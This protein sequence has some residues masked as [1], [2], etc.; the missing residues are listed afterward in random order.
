[1]EEK[2]DDDR[3]RNRRR[4]LFPDETR[5]GDTILTGRGQLEVATYFAILD[6][7]TM[8]LNKRYEA[9]DGV[10]KKIRFV[11]TLKESA[12]EV[13]RKCQISCRDDLEEVFSTD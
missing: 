10:F 5:E 12:Q 3:Q 4:K 7:V 6:R 8:E 13:T 9:Y 11:F 1:M 2:Y